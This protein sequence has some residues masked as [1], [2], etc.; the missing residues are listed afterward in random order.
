MTETI[1]TVLCG[2]LLVASTFASAAETGTVTDRAERFLAGVNQAG[3]HFEQNVG[4]LP[5]QVSFAFRTRDYRFDLIPNG[6]SLELPGNQMVLG[7]PMRFVFE[8]ALPEP[9]AF[10]AEKLPF[11][12]MH[13]VSTDGVRHRM[14]SVPTFG[15]VRV[16]TMY[17]GIDVRYH[18]NSGRVEF[19]FVVAPG[20]DPDQIAIH[21]SGARDVALENSGDLRIQFPV[22][23]VIQHKP[24]VYQDIEGRRVSVAAQYV[25]NDAGRAK[26]SV[27]AY[28]T[29]VP[30]VIDPILSVIVPTP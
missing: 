6:I 11:T 27:G 10:G 21:A 26:I 18:V 19:D 1:G 29:R 14:T 5:S 23:D 4:Q 2:A 24:I 17:D 25:L 30:L 20:A 7:D 3:A 16:E 28:D 15:E 8:G 22:V 9:T 13:R 12:V